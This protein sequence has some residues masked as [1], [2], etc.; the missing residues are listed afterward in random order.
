MLSQS[1]LGPKV[2]ASGPRTARI[3]IVGE[4][5][6]R[7][8]VEQGKP[9]VGESGRVLSSLLEETGISRG[10][11]FVTN[12]CKYRPPGNDIS[13]WIN[14]KKKPQ[15]GEVE[16]KG[17]WVRPWVQD[18][19]AELYRDIEEI[20]PNLIIAAGGAALWAL[21]GQKGISSWRGSLECYT[22][23]SGERIKVIPVYHPAAI[24][25]QWS[26]RYI[27]AHD[28]RRCKREAATRDF[29]IVSSVHTIRPSIECVITSLLKII[30]KLEAQDYVL[31][32]ADLETRGGHIACIGLAWSRDEALCIPFMCRDKEEGYWSL[33]DET[34][35]VRLL[36]EILTHPKVRV[37]GQNFLY[38][39]QYIAKE[40]GFIAN[41]WM[42]TMIAQS[43]LFPGLQKDLA[44]LASLFAKDYRFW[45]E[46]GKE[47]NER[48]LSEDRNWLY[49]CKD[50]CYTYE[51][52]EAQQR[53]IDSLKLRDVYEFQMGLFMPVLAMMLQGCKI[54]LQKRQEF[55][56]E[57]GQQ[58]KAHAQWI[59]DVLG[60]ELN[61]RSPTQMK[62]LFYDDLQ[63]PVQKNKKTKK[64]SLDDAALQTLKKKEP[65]LIPLIDKIV[66]TRS[67]GIFRS[68]FVEAE[69]DADNRIRCYFNIAGTE[70]FRFSSSKNAFGRGAN[71][72]T[73]PKGGAVDEGDPDALVLPNVRK[74]FAPDEGK[75]LLDCDL[76]RADLQVVVWE[77]DDRELKQMLREGVDIHKENAKVL[78][79]SRQM[80]KMF[81]HGTNY[82]GSA[83]TMAANT[84]LLVKQAEQMQNRWF[85]AHPKIKDWH[86]RISLQLLYTRTVNNKFG[87]RRFYFDR[88]E[89]LL[90][91]ALAWVPQSTVACVIN[92]GLKNLYDNLAKDV[93]ILLQV[94]DS[95]LLQIPVAKAEE[96]QPKIVEYLQ[97]KIP[98]PDPLI[99]PVGCKVGLHD[100]GTLIEWAEYKKGKAA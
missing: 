38:D 39:A 9:F 51:V 85:Q 17:R 83:R 82:G 59:K 100:W 26:W 21:L 13:L 23:A 3:M 71:L 94:H 43:V 97:I 36:E 62:A 14:E 50:A 52:A 44:F 15:P 96:L 98:Y 57:L 55:S 45:K 27:T 72:Q 46:E 66:E 95:L 31:L 20:K 48:E 35:I 34:E 22:T 67:L 87:Y 88:M 32:S 77:A 29:P 90:P 19:C 74:I 12:V 25:Y 92:R 89:D 93:D 80:A 76:D 2:L 16:F 24:L 65:L 28:L 73:I 18:G 6:G 64:A 53:A 61:P 5:P 42:D 91:E 30:H 7:E 4:A 99:I 11:C 40:W 47:W 84:G 69:L 33:E 1:M 68:N 60:H 58:M 49:N 81:V 8:E 56:L 75:L 10:D 86:K 70:T 41:V 63:L 37:I 78:S 54:D 79:C